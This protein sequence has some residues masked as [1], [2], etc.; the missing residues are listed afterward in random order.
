MNF[1]QLLE[2]VQEPPQGQPYLDVGD[3]MVKWG[4]KRNARKLLGPINLSYSKLTSLKGSPRVMWDDHIPGKGAIS[5]NFS[6]GGNPIVDLQGAPKYIEGNFIAYGCP[7][8]VSA[9]GFP[10]YVGGFA[11]LARTG[12][13]QEELAKHDVGNKVK[14]EIYLS[15]TGPHGEPA[16]KIKLTKAYLQA[17][18][19][20]S[21]EE[22]QDI[23]EI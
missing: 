18:K 15:T 16:D 11:N 22:Q 5:A 12:L 2:N 21:T 20:T 8:L 23:T 17:Q 6:V 13:T 4:V 1:D 19:H 14:G 10:D 7:L 3:F 9:K